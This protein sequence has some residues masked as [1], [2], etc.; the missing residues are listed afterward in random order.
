MWKS[1]VAKT[2]KNV[3]YERGLALYNERAGDMAQRVKG[4]AAKPNSLSLI[5]GT[6][7]VEGE[8]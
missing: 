3:V 4:T 7:M 5:R 8:T 6:P 1:S 2:H